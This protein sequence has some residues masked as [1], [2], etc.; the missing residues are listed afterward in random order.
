MLEH[1]WWG[2]VFLLGRAGD[3]AA[4]RRRAAAAARVPRPDARPLD[5]RSAA[6]SLAAVLSVIYGLK[7]FAQ[8]GFGA[9]P[10]LSVG[11]RDRRGRR[12][13]RAGSGGWPT[14]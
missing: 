6:L 3:G 5:L 8:D 7:L 12:L 13:R 2:S 4:A 10:L 11:R 14:R 1:F 9:V